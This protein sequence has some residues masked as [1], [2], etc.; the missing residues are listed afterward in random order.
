VRRLG[1]NRPVRDI[2]LLEELVAD[3][4]AD[5]RFALFVIGLFA[6]V[7]VVL[8][9]VGVYGVVAYA[10]A[11]RAREIAVRLA[12]GESPRRL[13]ARVLS[14][15]ARWTVMGL[16]AGLGGAALMARS[17]E[18]L[19]FGV[20]PHDAVTFVGVAAALAGVALAASIIP[21]LAAARADPMR[22]LRSE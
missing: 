18:S 5:T 17:L 1:S 15:G 8:A 12:L 22:A 16:V 7:A 13:V 6:V 2:R 3:A 19:L 11:R 20:T 9:G 4:S 21:A 10:M 14:D